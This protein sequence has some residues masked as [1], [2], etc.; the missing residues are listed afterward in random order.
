MKCRGKRDTTLNIPRIVYHVFMLHISRKNDYLRD[1][2]WYS[3]YQNTFFE[4]YEYCRFTK[5][6]KTSNLI[7]LTCL[8]NH[9]KKSPKIESSM[10]ICW[11]GGVNVIYEYHWNVND[12]WLSLNNINRY[13][14]NFQI[15]ADFCKQCI[16]SAQ[17]SLF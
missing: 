16:I 7:F 10:N 12:I 15:F 4:G 1:S 9:W 11:W 5:V 13:S 6:I 8:H 14:L 17:P 3:C 2:V